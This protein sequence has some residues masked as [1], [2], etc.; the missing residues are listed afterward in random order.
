MPDIAAGFIGLTE[1][2]SRRVSDV[3]SDVIRTAV[4]VSTAA[5]NEAITQLL[6]IFVEDLQDHKKVQERYKLPVSGT[7]QP[8]DEYGKPRPV[9]GEQWYVQAYPLFMGGHAWGA[10]WI[11]LAKMTVQELNDHVLTALRADADWN[12]RHI[13]AVLYYHQ[14]WTF[15]DKEHGDLPIKP[16]AAGEAEVK[17]ITRTGQLVT[18]SHYRAQADPISAT[19]NPFP[20]LK[21]DILLFPVNNGP[22]ITYIHNDQRASVEALPGF[23][24]VADADIDEG[25]GS[26]RLRGRGPSGSLAEE[27]IGKVNGHWIGEWERM[28]SGYLLTHCLGTKV[29][30]R[31]Q[32]PESVLQGYILKQDTINGE[33]TFSW[34]RHAGYAPRNRVGV[35]L[36]KLGSA[37]YAPPGD[38]EKM[39][40]PI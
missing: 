29:V 9:Q 24:A 1:L 34:Y 23:V 14:P 26:D 5:Y 33:T 11:S 28:P 22:V 35:I 3:N 8:L 7:L 15:K 13:L 4:D 12:I 21:R 40:L 10:N 36:T 6:A 20:T 17:Y 31:R 27:I 18:A 32:Q 25:I 30:A 39:P 2:F 16:L 19:A 37:S 38:Y